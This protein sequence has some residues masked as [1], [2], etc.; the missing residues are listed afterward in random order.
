MAAAESSGGRGGGKSSGATR[1][2]EGEAGS[3]SSSAPRPGLHLVVLGHVDAG[4][5]GGRGESVGGVC[6]GGAGA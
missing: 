5:G 6:V 3:S 1:A 2:D 4:E